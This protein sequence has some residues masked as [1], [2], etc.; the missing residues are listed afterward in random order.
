MR[1]GLLSPRLPY[2]WFS[3]MLSSPMPVLANLTELSLLALLLTVEVLPVEAVVV[4]ALAVL[5]VAP[6]AWLAVVPAVLLCCAF[7]AAKV[8]SSAAL[9]AA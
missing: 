5:V 2:F 4:P 9:V 1:L 3:A 7:C 6:V 8:R